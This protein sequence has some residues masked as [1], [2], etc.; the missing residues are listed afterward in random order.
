MGILKTDVF[1]LNA[2][3]IFVASQ[4]LN[5]IGICRPYGALGI[6]YIIS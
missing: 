4:K 1:F 3:M 6:F 5:G 2:T